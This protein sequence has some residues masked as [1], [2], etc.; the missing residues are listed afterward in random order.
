MK[1]R[2]RAPRIAAQLSLE[3]R[4]PGRQLASLGETVNISSNGVYFRSEYF[5]AEGTKL[6]ILIHLPAE[7]GL[8]EATVQP[9]GLVVRCTPEQED[10]SVGEYEVACFFMEMEEQDENRL[11]AFLTRKLES[12]STR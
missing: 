5:M 10:P 11:T 3:L 8:A 4:L 9:E 6:P 12:P 1:E 2:R 7:N